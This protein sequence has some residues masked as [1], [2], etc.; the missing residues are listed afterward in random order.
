MF[1]CFLCELFFLD[2]SPYYSRKFTALQHRD[3]SI[4]NT[5][6]LYRYAHRAKSRL[7]ADVWEMA[8][9]SC[10]IRITIDQ[11]CIPH[12]KTI[13]KT[14]SDPSELLSHPLIFWRLETD[15]GHEFRFSVKTEEGENLLL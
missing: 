3:A 6:T 7:V 15:N 8:S 2:V 13:K 10:R 11:I 12:I 1:V 14:A 4:R 9:E 5:V